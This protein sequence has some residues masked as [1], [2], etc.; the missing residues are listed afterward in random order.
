MSAT[1]V[2][3]CLWR[4]GGAGAPRAERAGQFEIQSARP[5]TA[6]HSTPFALRYLR[7]NG[8]GF[9]NQTTTR[10]DVITQV[11]ANELKALCSGWPGVVSSIKWEDDLVF[12]VAAKMFA[13]FCLRGP[14]R[15]R[16]SFKVDPERFLELT[17]Q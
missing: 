12:S 3:I 16:L 7:T 9:S 2:S 8:Y 14:D 4:C 13:V 6:I 15:E 5:R 11:K 10:K 1:V 17:D